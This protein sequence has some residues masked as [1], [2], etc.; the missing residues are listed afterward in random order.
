MMS[1]NV[2][3]RVVVLLRHSFDIFPFYYLKFKDSSF[4]YPLAIVIL[5]MSIS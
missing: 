2:N 1:V 5:I 3:Q 4:G